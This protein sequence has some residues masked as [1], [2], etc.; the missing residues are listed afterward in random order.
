MAAANGF[1][2]V[3]PDA[4]Y[5]D[6]TSTLA[7]T[8]GL[9][10][11]FAAPTVASFSVSEI[12]LYASTN[13]THVKMAIFADDAVNGCPGAMVAGSESGAIT[14]TA[15]IATIHFYT[16]GTPILL[17]GG[18]G[19]SY[20]IA[21]IHNATSVTSRF[22]TGGTGVNVTVSSLYLADRGSGGIRTRQ[23]AGHV[24]LRRLCVGGVYSDP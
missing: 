4:R 9:A 5:G 14:L 16:Y 11:K 13:L 3:R 12:G 8:A 24:V 23:H 20:W 6:T 2:T 22:A 1:V 19:V 21:Q 15:D 18:A 17:A 7:S 10:T